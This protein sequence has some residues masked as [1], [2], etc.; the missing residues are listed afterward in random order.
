[1]K[2]IKIQVSG[3]VAPSGEKYATI[4]ETEGEDERQ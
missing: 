3:F 4:V 2:A 1:M